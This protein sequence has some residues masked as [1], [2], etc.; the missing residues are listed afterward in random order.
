ML[1]N[2]GSV[3]I[4]T[5]LHKRELESVLDLLEF[6][7]SRNDLDSEQKNAYRVLKS[8]Y[9]KIEGDSNIHLKSYINR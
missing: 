1:L 3:Y 5:L 7:E 2:D 6:H 8:F 9:L 4:G